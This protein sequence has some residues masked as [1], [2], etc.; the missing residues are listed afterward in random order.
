M[1]ASLKRNLGFQAVYQIL[2]TCL[3]LI[4]APYLARVLG[5][6]K[7][8]IFSFTS[9]VVMYFTLIAML[10][11]VNYGTRS[12]A[13]VKESK[14]EL[15]HAFWS[16]YSLQ[17]IISLG[18]LI[19]YILYVIFLCKDNQIIAFIQTIAILDCFLNISW[20]FFGLEKF[21]VT[22]T[23]SFFVKIL[24]VVAIVLLVKKTSDLWLYTLI[25]LC[26]TLISDLVLWVYLPRSISF[27]RVKINDI[28]GHLKPNLMLFI[29]LLAMSLYHIMDKTMLGILSNYEQSGF[30]YNADKIVNI[31]ASLISGI[32]TVMLPRMTSLTSQ[33]KREESDSLFKLSLEGTVLIGTAMAFGIAAIANEFVPIFFG[34]GYEECIILTI[35]LAPILIIKSFT[36]TASYQFL[37]PHNKEKVYIISACVGATICFIA[38]LVLI[39][40]Y[41]AM[42]AVI[43]ILLAELGACTWQLI[44]ISKLINIGPTLLKCLGY[45]LIGI[46]MFVVVRGIA[47]LELY[48]V[49]QIII[50]ITVGA[51][52]FLLSCQ[53]YWKTTRNSIQRVIFGPV[54]KRLRSIH[55]E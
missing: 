6:E 20:F 24:T 42:G 37:I 53:L 46:F 54:L 19:A 35:V 50:E 17:A 28:V 39:P 16:I 21:Q 40:H 30:Y 2:N 45:S 14:I 38:N 25:M 15:S 8:G 22:V 11:T 55:K 4:T 52:V 13:T 3:P 49:A 47:K 33:G 29:P 12:V 32:S 34:P 9:S 26:G 7:L 51:L 23:R 43:G 36:F 44:S 18:S 41:G 1:Q 5:A 31:T 27:E 48:T 10:G